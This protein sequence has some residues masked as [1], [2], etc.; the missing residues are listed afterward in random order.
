MVVCNNETCNKKAFFN[1]AG[2][3]AISCKTHKLPG[4]IDVKNKKCLECSKNPLFNFKG[5]K[6]GIYC[7]SHKK[8]NM[9]NVTHRMCIEKIVINRHHLMLKVNL[10]NI[11]VVTKLKK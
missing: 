1:Y 10:R 7:N 2:E 8:D 11:A 9:V 6:G 5:V 3:K 4:M